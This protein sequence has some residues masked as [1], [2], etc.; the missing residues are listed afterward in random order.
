[1]KKNKKYLLPE[2][3]D[4]LIKDGTEAFANLVKSGVYPQIFINERINAIK[5]V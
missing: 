2:M 5:R 3:I 4:C 1:M